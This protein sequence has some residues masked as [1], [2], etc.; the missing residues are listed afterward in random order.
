MLHQAQDESVS[1]EVQANATSIGHPLTRLDGDRAAA[2]TR[3]GLIAIADSVIRIIPGGQEEARI[4]AITQDALGNTHGEH[5]V[6]SGRR[7]D[8]EQIQGPVIVGPSLAVVSP[9]VHL[10]GLELVVV[11]VGGHRGPRG[12]EAVVEVFAPYHSRAVAD[13][14]A[15]GLLSGSLRI[16]GGDGSVECAG[17]GRRAGDDAVGVHAQSWRKACGAKPGPVIRRHLPDK[18]GVAHSRRQRCTGEHWRSERDLLG[19]DLEVVKLDRDGVSGAVVLQREVDGGGVGVARPLREEGVVVKCL[20]G[21]AAADDAEGAIRHSGGGDAVVSGRRIKPDMGVVATQTA[22]VAT[23]GRSKLS[24]HGAIQLNL[25]APAAT[26]AREHE[27][28]VVHAHI[29]VAVEGHGG[30]GRG[31]F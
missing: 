1:G 23:D 9:Q 12:G 17:G 20:D 22:L 14:D 28:P 11:G 21:R 30:I 24:G 15:K 18:R 3:T 8:G 13:D 2:I 25:V 16:R 27:V 5:E 26:Q 19:G 4:V 6:A 7:V 10:A 29:E 31:P